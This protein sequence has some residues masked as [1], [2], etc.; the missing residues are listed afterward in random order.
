M[1]DRFIEYLRTELA[2]SPLTLKVYRTDLTD[3]KNFVAHDNDGTADFDPMSI[4]TNDTRAWVASLGRRGLTGGTIKHK[5]SAV[6]SLYN[7][8]I[9]RH[10]ALS[11]PAARVTVN[12]REKP[13]P[14]FIAPAEMNRVLTELDEETEGFTSLRNSLV[15]NLLYQTGMRASEMVNLTDERVDTARSELKVLGKRNKERLIP[16]GD[17]LKSLIDNYRAVRPAAIA[18]GQPFLVD[19]DGAPLNYNRVYAIVR[20]ALDGRVS[21]SKRSPHVLRHSFATDLLNNGADLTS[22][23]KLLG[24]ESLATTQIYTHVSVAELRDSYQRAHP[25]A[26]HDK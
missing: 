18:P 16:F 6:R 11:N 9:K 19:E 1:I 8:M 13:L 23:R 12:R 25:R 24:H 3:W 2:Y 21:S 26:R 20:N 5:L 17:S 7:W 22:V 15:L 4:T 14:K 10:G